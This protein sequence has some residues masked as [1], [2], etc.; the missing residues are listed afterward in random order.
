MIRCSCQGLHGCVPVAPSAIPSESQSAS[1]CDRRSAS[2]R[3]AS[4][5]LSQRPVFTSTSEAISSPA[6][7]GLSSLP[8]AAA[9]MSSK[10]L[11]RE[12]L[13]GSRTAN[14][15]STA[16]VRSVPSSN[17]S[18]ARSICSSALSFCSSPICRSTVAGATRR[19]LVRR[20]PQD[21]GCDVI[22]APARRLRRGARPPQAERGRPQTARGLRRASPPGRRHPR[23]RSSSG[24]A[25]PAGTRPRAPRRSRR[26][27][28]GARPAGARRRRP[29]RRR[30][31]RTPP[32]R[33]TASPRRRRAA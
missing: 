23:S 19:D 8:S 6:R 31:C 14:S 10:R 17:C 32:G 29:P 13:A 4:S 26:G 33:W 9:W 25:A 30:P 20:K 7:C 11:T 28:N 2:F 16:S 24:T 12:R 3:A 18:R 5:K 22:P 1:T 27:P 15:S 21:L